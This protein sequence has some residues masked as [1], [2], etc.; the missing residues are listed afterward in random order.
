MKGKIL[1]VDDD[2][3]HLHMLRTLLKSFGHE[4]ESAMDAIHHQVNEGQRAS[5]RVEQGSR[6]VAAQMHRLE[7]IRQAQQEVL[8][9]LEQALRGYVLDEAPLELS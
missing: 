1:I 6:Q 2:T 5:T 9:D 7:E 8:D 4:V 3:A